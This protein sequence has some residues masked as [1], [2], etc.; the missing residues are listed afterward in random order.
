MFFSDIHT[1]ILYGADD[2]PKTKE[3]MFALADKIYADG[4]RLLCATPHCY[5]RWC[6][7]NRRS[8]DKAFAELQEYCGEKYPDL[9]LFLGNE[10]YMD[11]DSLNWLKNGFCKPMGN[12]RYVLAEFSFTQPEKHIIRA[13]QSLLNSGYVPII[14]HAE[15]YTKLT[16]KSIAE[17][18][19]NGAL[20][21]VNSRKSFGGFDFLEKRRLKSIL[22]NRLADIVSTDAHDMGERAPCMPEF[23][24]AVTEKYGREY[25]DDIFRNNAEK[26]FCASTT[27]EVK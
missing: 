19:R 15:R 18:R 16:L 7:D 27:E 17:L 13:V 11:N 5:P 14:A 3:E 23:Y 12:T 20:I 2:G 9:R 10:L 26:L 6:G 8:A 1:H 4:I 25:A 21:Q 24:Q 22:S